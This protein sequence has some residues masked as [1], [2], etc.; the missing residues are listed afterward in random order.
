M[1]ST[2]CS[3]WKKNAAACAQ[4]FPILLHASQTYH[5]DTESAQY[6]YAPVRLKIPNSRGKPIIF[7]DVW[8]QTYKNRVDFNEAQRECDF[9]LDKPGLSQPLD[10]WSV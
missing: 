6:C 3:Q 5:V 8:K 2:I 1:S 10:Q 4:L 7:V 9:N